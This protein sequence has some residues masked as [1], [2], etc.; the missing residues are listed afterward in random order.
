MPWMETCRVEQRLRFVEAARDGSWNV[1]ELCREFGISRKT[2]YKWLG[3]YADDGIVGLRDRSTARL[4]QPDRIEDSVRVLIVRARR[5]HPT[6]GPKKLLAW[7]A[8]QHPRIALPSRSTAATILKDAGLIVARKRRRRLVGSSGGLTGGD[9]ANS[10]WATD[11]KGQ[12]R[13]SNQEYCYPLTVTDLH[14]RYVLACRGFDCICWQAVRRAYIGLFRRFGVPDAIRSDNGSPFASTGAGRLTR[15]SVFWIDQGIRLQRI[16]PG[17]PQQNGQH[18]RMHW[19]L[20]NETASPP[21]QTMRAQQRRFDRFVQCFNEERPHEALA[22]ECP[23]EFYE[24]SEREYVEKPDAADYPSHYAVRL[25]QKNGSIKLHGR[26]IFVSECLAGR[27]V[28]LLEI[29]DRV[30][31]VYFRHHR[32]GILKTRSK[33]ARITELWGSAPEA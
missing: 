22:M 20:K 7:L 12:F 3:R 15:L 19:T 4:T 1:S 17:C 33:S 2:A 29:E 5:S 32:I 23:A 31:K 13:L 24:Q 16:E 14:S 27:H 28:G 25:V 6:W 26:R 18:E 10:V 11:F 21:A 8:R 9:R 30:W